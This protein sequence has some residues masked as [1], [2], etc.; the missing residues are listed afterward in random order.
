MPRIM[1]DENR[2]SVD[3]SKIRSDD[4][5]RRIQRAWGPTA[6]DGQ[7]AGMTNPYLEF[8]HVYSIP[9]D[10][11]LHP[12][13]RIQFSTRG[14]P[15][16]RP[17]F[18]LPGTPGT[19][20]GPLPS[21]E[22]LFRN[23]IFLVSIDRPGCGGS[24]PF[25]GR[26]VADVRRD[27][28]QV[29]RALDIEEFYVAGRSG[30]GP[31]ALACARM[32]GVLGVVALAGRP[33]VEEQPWL[34]DDGVGYGRNQKVFASRDVAEI[35]ALLEPVVH[36]LHGDSAAEL[37]SLEASNLSK[38]DRAIL[39]D[40]QLR[41]AIAISHGYSVDR[42]GV[43][44]WA[45]D[46]VAISDASGWDS[47]TFGE[48]CPIIRL[49]GRSDGLV[50]GSSTSAWGFP[51]VRLDSRYELLPFAREQAWLELELEK[52]SKRPQRG[53]SFIAPSGHF[54]AYKLMMPLLETM[55]DLVEGRGVNGWAYPAREKPM[56]THFLETAK[57]LNAIGSGLA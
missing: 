12:K 6:S 16:G 41:E 13:R 1:G 15:Q 37:V 11:P 30:G 43:E 38:T 39:D 10:D 8:V 22:R 5:R 55:F 54:S 25:P 24:D 9:A 53:I 4:L 2:V 33:H 31:H 36:R 27:V 19:C 44:G 23:R 35:R 47:S 42:F 18:L 40:D 46:N 28:Q 17:V 3:I 7:Q 29:A 26:A 50:G 20:I 51:V 57:R 49:Q 45:A 52:A 34:D 21:R 32:E 56:I 48:N 14:S